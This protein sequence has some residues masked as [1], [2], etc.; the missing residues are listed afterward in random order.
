M[1]ESERAEII[2]AIR[3]VAYVTIF[4]RRQSRAAAADA[5]ARLSVQGDGLHAR[6][7]CPRRRSCGRTAARSS[8][9]AIRRTTPRPTILRENARSMKRLLVLRL[10]AL[11]D[12]IHTIPAVVALRERADE[13]TWV[14]E[15][16]YRELVEIVAGVKTIPVRMKTVAARS[17]RAARDARPRGCAAPTPS[18]DFQGLIKSAVLGMAVGREDAY[19]LRSHAIREKPAL[20]FTNRKVHVDTSKHVVDQNLQ[21]ASAHTEAA[22]AAT[23]LQNWDAFPQPVPGYED[24]IVL[25]PG[26]GKPEQAL[27]RGALPRARRAHRPEGAGGLGTGGAGAGRGDRRAHGAADEPPRARL[28]PAETPRSSSA[29]TPARSISPLPSA[30]RSSASTDRP[31]RGATDPIGQ[32]ATLHRSFSRRRNGWNR[33]LLKRS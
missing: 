18:I 4:R 22:A 5:A 14:V 15:A 13:I 7:P 9:S 27:A 25:L 11:G 3:G 33:S 2:S 28:D 8:S 1:P 30:R 19:R 12:V 17:A 24:A 29:A 23:A 20:L 21:L 31:I 6:T 32:L 26:A 16:P 10:S